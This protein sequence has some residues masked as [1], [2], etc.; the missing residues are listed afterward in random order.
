VWIAE[1]KDILSAFFWVLTMLAY[2]WYVELPNTRRYF[3]VLAAFTLGLM[4][5]PMLVT[6]PFVLLLM[7]Y[8]P[9]RRLQSGKIGM[10]CLEKV[11][12]LFIALFF[13][14]LAYYA[15]AKGGAV[16][17]LGRLGLGARAANS[18]IS[19][20]KYM[21]QMLWPRNL[22]VIYPHPGSEVSPVSAL[23]AFL[24]LIVI[25]V[26]VI[27]WCKD[28]P[29]VLFGWLWYLGTLVPVIGIVQFGSHAMADRFTY[30]PFIGMFVAIAW[31]IPDVICLS[32]PRSC[33]ILGA[34]GCCT[35]MALGTCTFIQT[36]YWKDS[37]R[38]F[39]R[40]LAVT[41]RNYVAHLNL[42]TALAD[43]KQYGQAVRHYNAAI[44]I[45]P[46][47]ANAHFNLAN[48][49]FLMGDVRGAIEHYQETLRLDPSFPDAAA[50]LEAA[51]ACLM[52]RRKGSAPVL[53]SPQRDA[54]VRHF[55]EGVR[56]ESSGDMSGAVSEYREA[57]RLDPG[58]AEAHCNLGVILKD[59]GKLDDAIKEYRK[60]LEIRSDFAEAHGNLAVAL[61]FKG[62]YAEAWKEVELCRKYGV[63]PHPDFIKALSEK[64]PEPA[65][66]K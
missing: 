39:S 2:S 54:A 53:R 4:A 34:A 45:Y 26:F 25:S 46:D 3:A 27:K 47:Q 61:Y 64:M 7:D 17:S 30:I 49:L 19:Y 13:S 23:G 15:Q 50:N 29:Y 21:W 35:L 8:W 52:G 43:R 37:V 58:F 51:N 18:L 33:A 31:G 48:A 57:I 66:E 24:I 56:L 28:R 59:Q 63:E 12:F 62:R 55:R 11:P 9:L 5:K 20:V 60:A 1:R 38:L 44:E 41:E 42:A 10:L 32:R 65:A 40:A 36:G 22:A 16:S 6:L 14:G